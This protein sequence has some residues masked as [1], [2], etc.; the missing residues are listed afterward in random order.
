MA[1][2]MFILL[3]MFTSEQHSYSKDDYK[4]KQIKG[5]VIEMR[6]F[7]YFLKNFFLRDF[8]NIDDTYEYFRLQN[9]NVLVG[10]CFEFHAKITG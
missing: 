8:N 2:D 1:V 10:H 7:Q 9:N 5:T 6:L 3:T 4:C